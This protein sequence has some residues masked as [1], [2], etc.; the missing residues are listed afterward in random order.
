[1]HRS[2]S[3]REFTTPAFPVYLY[4]CDGN[5]IVKTVNDVSDTCSLKCKIRIPSKPY[6]SHCG[7]N[8]P[9]PLS[10]YLV[11]LRTN[12]LSLPPIVTPFFFWA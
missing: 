7:E 11:Q 1:M 3:I 6:S 12:H 4:D 2:V 9:F 5:Y 8:L 10:L